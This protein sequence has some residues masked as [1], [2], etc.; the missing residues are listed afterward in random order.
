MHVLEHF[1]FFP[2]HMAQQSDAGHFQSMSDNTDGIARS[3]LPRF[4]GPGQM[5]RVNGIPALRPEDER[6]NPVGQNKILGLRIERA[7]IP[8]HGQ[9]LTRL[10]KERDGDRIEEGLFFLFKEPGL[11]GID[12]PLHLVTFRLREGKAGDSGICL[13]HRSGLSRRWRRR[14][15]IRHKQVHKITGQHDAQ[16]E[17]PPLCQCSP[18]FICPVP[19]SSQPLAR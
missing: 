19:H 9:F 12:L 10:S 6:F 15:R 11:L 4:I 5:I 18:H 8:F 13:I 1:E 2:V 17:K 7:L 16:P 3:N 14:R